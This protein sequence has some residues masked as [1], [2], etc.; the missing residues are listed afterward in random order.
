MSQ[1][2]KYAWFNLAAF[3]LMVVLYVLIVVA[4]SVAS[5]RL[6]MVAPG[7][8]GAMGFSAL[9]ALSISIIWRT[10]RGKVVRDEREVLICQRA[11]RIAYG[12]FWSLFAIACLALWGGGGSDKL[13]PASIFLYLLWSAWITFM[14]AQS[15]AILFQYGGEHSHVTE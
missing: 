6:Q 12:I 2:Q 10:R 4:H 1:L 7:V 13:V 9:W 15:L 5:G 14:V 3:A 11:T 8:S